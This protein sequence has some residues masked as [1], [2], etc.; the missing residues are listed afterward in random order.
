[1]ETF[2]IYINNG[3]TKPK[4]VDKWKGRITND[5]LKKTL[6]GICMRKSKSSI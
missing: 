3:K 1:M 6:E 4:I 2:R 5:G